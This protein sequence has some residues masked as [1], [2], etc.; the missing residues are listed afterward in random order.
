M[1]KTLNMSRLG[2]NCS[3]TPHNMT[4]DVSLIRI[5]LKDPTRRKTVVWCQQEYKV[6]N[7]QAKSNTHK[8]VTERL[9]QLKSNSYM[10]T[11]KSLTNH[12]RYIPH[13]MRE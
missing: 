10:S 7:Q 6:E 1:T 8:Y 11:A 2:S 4:E 12:K 9:D 13:D 5:S 3:D